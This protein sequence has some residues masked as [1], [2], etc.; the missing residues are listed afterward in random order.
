MRAFTQYNVRLDPGARAKYTE[1]VTDLLRRDRPH[2]TRRCGAN[3]FRVVKPA[4]SGWG[5]FIPLSG[6][7]TWCL[8]FPAWCPNTGRMLDFA[9]LPLLPGRP[10]RQSEYMVAGPCARQ[11]I[12]KNP[13]A[14]IRLADT[15]LE[16][17]QIEYLTG[18]PAA[19][20]RQ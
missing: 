15:I 19:C 17:V 3:L 8:V 20:V 18:S 11:A 14:E 10:A 13:G 6:K 4:F 2:L 16:A 5:A 1:A 12:H 9:A 7:F